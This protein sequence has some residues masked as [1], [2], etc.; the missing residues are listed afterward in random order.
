METTKVAIF[1]NAQ[2]I[3]TSVLSYL[4][5]HQLISKHF[6]AGAVLT[7]FGVVLTELG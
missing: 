4:F 5:L 7:L 6:F 1:A 2:P 3:V